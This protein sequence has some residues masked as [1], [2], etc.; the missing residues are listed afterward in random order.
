MVLKRAVKVL[1]KNGQVI[2]RDVWLDA[3]MDCEMNGNIMTGQAIVKITL[4]IGVELEDQIRT[5]LDDA[6]NCENKNRYE[7]ARAI[8]ALLVENFKNDENAWLKKINFEMR[9]LKIQ[10]NYQYLD[11][12]L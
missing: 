12:D 10:P 1:Q 8:L 6:E 11:A 4:E 7:T 5:F 9:M 3:A 2:K